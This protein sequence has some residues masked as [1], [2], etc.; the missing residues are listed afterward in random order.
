M[1]DEK[2][3]ARRDLVAAAV[4][5]KSI[6]ILL[7]AVMMVSGIISLVFIPKDEFPE[8]DLPFGVVVGIYPGAS[9]LEVEQQ[10]T[11]PLET[12]LWT[13]K[14]IDKARTSTISRNGM[15]IALVF[16]KRTG[17]NTEF[18]NKL[19]ERLPLLRTQL[20]SGV[21]G[22]IA[23]E[24]FGDVSAMLITIESEQKTFR[25]MTE[26]MDRLCD[27]LRTIPSLANIYQLGNQKEQIGI[28]LDRN[29]LPAYGL[30]TPMVY[31]KL[32]G[33]MGT[34][35]T[36]NLDD[37]KLSRNL[38][39]LPTLNTEQE[40][41]QTIIY[42]DPAG[43]IVRLGDI[44]DVR[45]EY[46]TMKR[47]I[48]NNGHQC[49][50]LSL[51]MTKG[52]NIV[53]FGEDVKAILSDFEATL[54]PEV[55]IN[56]I[57]DQSQVVEDSVHEFLWEMLIAIISVIIV[58]MLM[59][60]LRVAGVA[61]VTIPIT[62]F[63]SIACFYVFGIE[64]NSIT[65]AAMIVSLGMIVDDSVVVIDSYL[66]KLD[67]GVPRWRAAIESAQKFTASI[68]T[69][70]LAISITFFP[71]LFTTESF[72]HKF[73]EPFPYGLTIV[74]TVS[75][76]VALFVVP[77]IEYYFVHDGL[78][79]ST[80]RILTIMQDFY[81]RLLSQC[82]HHRRI[83]LGI[84]M[85]VVLLSLLLFPMIPQK[86]MP[87]ATR[88]L[89]TVDVVLPSGTDITRTAA[90][91]DSLVDILS[92]DKRVTNIT[93]FYGSGSPRI[94]AA[95]FPEFGGTHFAQLIVNT[96]S[97]SEMQEVLDEY[98]ERMANY[99]TDAQVLFR[100]IA[101]TDAIYPVMVRLK[102]DNLDSMRVATD[103]VLTRLRHNPK[104]VTVNSNWGTTQSRINIALH[105]EEANRIGMTK[106]LLAMNLAL[107][108]SGGIPV[109]SIWEGSTEVPIMLRD[110]DEGKQTV[111]AFKDI[112]VSGLVP[113]LTTVP[114]TQVAGITPDWNNGAIIRSNG[115]R[116]TVC[117]A[118]IS[119]DAKVA[120]LTKEIYDDLKTLRLPEGITIKQGGQAETETRYRPQIYLGVV[121]A[122]I[123]IVFILLFHLRSIPLM[124][125]L[126]GSLIF[127]IPGGL[128][129]L[130]LSGFELGATALLGYITLM[131]IIVRCG[132]IMVD[133]AE[134][135][136]RDQ[137]LTAVEAAQ[138][139]AQH[140]FRPIFLTSAA[141]SMGVIP[142]VLKGTPLWGPMGIVICIGALIS[143]CFIVTMIPA[144]YS[145]VIKE[146]KMTTPQPTHS[147]GSAARTTLCIMALA[148][149]LPLTASAQKIMTLNECIETARVNNISVRNAQN[150]LLIAR[151]QQ[152]YA[153]SKYYPYVAASA[154]HFEATDYLFKKQL[155]ND[156]LQEVIEAIN[157]E[158]NLGF[159]FYNISTLQNGTTAGIS[160]IQPIYTGGLLTSINKLAD[161]QVTARKEMQEMTYDQLVQQTELLYYLL[162]KLHGK[163]R[164]LTSMEEEV[165][166]ILKDAQNLA[167][168]GIVNSND[169][170]SVELRQNQLSALHLRLDNAINLGRRALAKHIGLPNEDIDID[171]TIV[172]DIVKPDELWVNSLSAIE[173]RSET[174]LLDLNVQKSQLETKMA[175]A[176]QRPLLILGGNAG[177]SWFLSKGQFR[178]VGVAHV[179]IPLSAFWSESHRIK[180]KKIEEQKALDFRKDK[181]ELLDLQV[182]DA[183]DN[184]DNAYRQLGIAEKS[185]RHANENLRAKREMYINGVTNM[186]VLLDAQ[187]EQQQAYDQ[188]TDALCDYQQAKS[189]YL[190]LTGRR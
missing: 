186:T 137:G 108:Y 11:R 3:A 159:D 134:E 176:S 74:L 189:T 190:I 96:H 183:Y 101:Y 31:S 33:S 23:N 126:M 78:K 79:S 64:I 55:N 105:P 135:L 121:L 28:Y 133:Y 95:F 103:S 44:A 16:L 81:N 160:A 69:A 113:T 75:V 175:R 76:L 63:T 83:T 185:I 164:T 161:L 5:H 25:E 88:S 136:R 50:L 158:V 120:T 47:Y 62:I 132:I 67:E 111:E 163:S 65:L 52:N 66:E 117:F 68:I 114:L 144:A 87:R 38:H 17:D 141:A 49:I 93:A 77:I 34:M 149:L 140:R 102:G 147:E 180:Y 10:L 107:R 142:M 178:G 40:L 123:I 100:E 58:V 112:R 148:M 72:V 106:S 14:E 56:V 90:V 129:G 168:E 146:K 41:L 51:Q 84:G 4:H 82:M 26:Y 12:F 182:R 122:V 48:K 27:R 35:I 124:L 118:T 8:L 181:R 32:S 143:M 19:K 24:D 37:G 21:M 187:R 45:R 167:D 18:W 166:S 61:V 162:M 139:S 59:M 91:T 70:T 174:R 152:K 98:T 94:H 46:P 188:H 116:E 2:K 128:I 119:R 157:K 43:G 53:K 130:F 39:I 6:V 54:P 127:S 145:L 80:P 150:D 179:S 15:S 172:T 36:G 138:L 99:F 86:L 170:L 60:P 173:L 85:A 7:C 89:F 20:P 154:M 169:V 109:S 57:S 155:F 151:E 71:L 131:G 171:T 156:E 30:N 110:A 165:G 92:R 73:I 22:V 104:L 125:V 1:R 115:I 153:R 13:F 29:R 177:G 97:D 42:S 184:L 9:E